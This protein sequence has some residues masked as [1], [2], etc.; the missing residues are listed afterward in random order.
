[1]FKI[2]SSLVITFL[3]IFS[4]QAFAAATKTHALGAVK[5]AE[6]AQTQANQVGYEWRD[7]D[8]MIKAAKQA[9]DNKDYSKAIKLAKVAEAQSH[10]AVKQYHSE[11]KRYTKNY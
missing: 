3:L 5:K 8:K 10:N 2:I 11:V 4:S 7:T 6:N 1:M 9:I